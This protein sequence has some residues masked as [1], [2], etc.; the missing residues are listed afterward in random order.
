MGVKRIYYLCG[1]LQFLFLL[2]LQIDLEQSLLLCASQIQLL[3]GLQV[4]EVLANRPHKRSSDKY[5]DLN[6]PADITHQGEDV[7]NLPR[8]L[9]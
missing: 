5:E 6:D 4:K 9:Y 3:N 7:I 8:L 2:L 1:V